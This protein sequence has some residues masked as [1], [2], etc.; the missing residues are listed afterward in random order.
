M[1]FAVWLRAR[2]VVGFIEWPDEIYSMWRT[3]G[4]LRSLINLT[5]ADWPPLYGILQW[6]WVRLVGPT[7]EASRFLSVL[8]SLLGVACAYRAARA[9]YR[10]NAAPSAHSHRAALVVTVMYTTMAYMIFAGVDARAYGLLLTLGALCVWLTARWLVK[11]TWR[12]AV[13]PA[14]VM[15]AMFYTSFTSLP[16]F[17][18]LSLLVLIFR[19]RLILRWA[20]IGIAALVLVIPILPKFI[21]NGFNRIEGGLPLPLPPFR[22][23]MQNTYRDFGGP[24]WFVGLIIVVIV[25]L[26][27]QAL[28]Q[29]GARRLFVLLAA[30]LPFPVVVY[31]FVD[32]EEFLKP[33]Y[34]WWLAFG[35]ALLMGSITLRFPRL[36]QYGAI[37]A[38]LCLPLIPVEFDN[39]RLHVTASPPF[40]MAFAWYAEHLRPGDVLI[41]DPQCRCG[42]PEGWDYFV[43]LYFPTGELPIVKEPGDASRVWY[44][45]TEGKR[46][47]QL[48]AEI[49]QERTPSI[50]VGPWNFLLRLYEGPPSW[51]GASFGDKVN[52]NGAEILDT[53]T[54]IGQGETFQVKLWWSVDQRLD[55]DYSI[56]LAVM[57]PSGSLVVQADGPPHMP[58]TPEQTSAWEPGVYYQ[59]IRTLR[60]PSPL[61]SG[62]YKLV[63]TVYQWW[64]GVRLPP[65]SNALWDLYK[66][67][68]T[69]LKLADLSVIGTV[70]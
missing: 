10:L 40:R 32:N 58:D 13:G 17:G 44:L 47:E 1:L 52:L 27:V 6:H 12:R 62:T 66:K 22:E 67:D 35:I 39:Y 4:S 33:R 43:P 49:E 11:P 56:S 51:E 23:A 61:R 50:F 30:W 57:D 14:A 34:M 3:Q 48:L 19:P 65:E 42:V 16:F 63:V 36:I 15:A 69:L 41:I 70:R 7:L 68:D 20:G 53:G 9:L 28:R 38:G 37:L 21:D 46:D 31:F 24:S 55:R 26:A 59:D 64:D 2:N 45:S 5:P 8:V 29:P 60:L 25:L 54:V 18:I